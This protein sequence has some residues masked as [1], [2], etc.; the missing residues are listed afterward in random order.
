MIRTPF[1]SEWDTS[2][3][4][5]DRRAHL[6]SGA[7]FEQIVSRLLGESTVIRAMICPYQTPAPGEPE[8]ARQIVLLISVGF[9]NCD[10]L[11]NAPDGLRARYW[12]SPDHGS[13]AT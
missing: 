8:D 5:A 4:P 9:E 12:Q 6:E 13:T 2:Q 11:Y 7:S 10:L 3:L 1:P